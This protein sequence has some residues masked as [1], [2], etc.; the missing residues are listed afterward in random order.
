M[1]AIIGLIFFIVVPILKTIAVFPFMKLM[2]D[3]FLLKKLFPFYS[4]FLMIK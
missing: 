1:A 3:P 4:R 2:D